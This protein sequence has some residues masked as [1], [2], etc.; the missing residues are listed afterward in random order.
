MALR[1][2]SALDTTGGTTEAVGARY[3]RRHYVS[4]RRAIRPAALRKLSAGQ[5]LLARETTGGQRF[6]RGKSARRKSQHFSC[7]Q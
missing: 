6:L 2:L 5:K 1:K 7:D 4:C 3:D